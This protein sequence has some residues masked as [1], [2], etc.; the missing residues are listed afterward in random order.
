MTDSLNLKKLVRIETELPSLRYLAEITRLKCMGQLLELKMFPN[1]KEITESQGAFY[2]AQKYLPYKLSNSDVNVVV[3]GDGT[4]P[5]TGALFALRSAWN[6]IS[7]DPQMKLNWNEGPLKIRR[8]TLI[9]E[10]VE[11]YYQDFGDNPLIIIHVHSHASLKSSLKS[12][13]S[14][15]TSIIAIPCCVKQV[16]IKNEWNNNKYE[17]SPDKVYRDN[18]I[19]SQKNE[20]KIWRRV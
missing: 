12:L 8:L 5:R 10:N 18:A 15:N 13:R 7:I 19:L 6:V 1:I 14:V 3:V 2:A 4:T 11:D 16:I 9:K 17:V 20:V